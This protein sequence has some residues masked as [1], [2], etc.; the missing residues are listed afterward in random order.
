MCALFLFC[1]RIFLNSKIQPLLVPHKKKDERESRC[2]R[3]SRG[4]SA[5]RRD[6][7]IA[8]YVNRRFSVLLRSILAA[9]PRKCA[10]EVR[11]CAG[12]L[13][14]IASPKGLSRSL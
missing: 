5:R 9:R 2:P 10:G 8:K 1:L 11:K 7:T 13:E 14:A 6:T 3:R 12:V 4:Q